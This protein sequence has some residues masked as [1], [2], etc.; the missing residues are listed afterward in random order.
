MIG[1]SIFNLLPFLPPYFIDCLKSSL[2]TTP[3]DQHVDVYEIPINM[4]NNARN[5]YIGVTK[6]KVLERFIEQ[7]RDIIQRRPE[8]ALSLF[9]FNNPNS[10]IDFENTRIVIVIVSLKIFRRNLFK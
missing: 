7:K 10:H 4:K 2:D 6:R 8:T 9:Y 1:G 5:F 3:G